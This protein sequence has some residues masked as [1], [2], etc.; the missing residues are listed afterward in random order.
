MTKRPD[1]LE[2]VL[3]AIELL[4]RIPRGRKVTASELHQQLQ[5][6]GIERDL[7][8]VQRQLEMLS[9]HFD[10]ERDERSKPYGYRWTEKARA[11][12]VPNLTPQKSLLLLLAEAHLKNLLPA[13]VMKSLQEFFRQ[14]RRNLG[15]KEDARL[16]R[17]WPE[18]VCVVAT[19]QPFP[20][21]HPES[22]RAYSK[23]SAMRFTTTASFIW[24]TSMPAASAA[25]SM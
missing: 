8:T 5:G 3:L 17:E 24:I 19:S 2:T 11:L 10:I 20:C 25:R 6:A 21:C 15:S 1:T 23:P 14:A 16:E 13:R 7:R 4:R 18:K 9:A 12:A 22:L